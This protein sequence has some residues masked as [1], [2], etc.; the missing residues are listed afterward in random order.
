MENISDN[1]SL[2]DPKFSLDELKTI[3]KLKKKHKLII[4]N[5]SINNKKKNSFP[6]ESIAVNSISVKNF[7]PKSESKSKEKEKIK[8]VILY[9][10]INSYHVK[11]T[12]GSIPSKTE[13]FLLNNNAIFDRFSGSNSVFNKIGENTP[14][15]GS[16]ELSYDWN[17]KNN[18]VRI[19]ESE[20]KR[21]QNSFNSL[22][23]VGDYN[24]DNGK[25]IQKER[26]NLRYDSLYKR[27][28]TLFNQKINKD[29]EN[30]EYYDPKNINEIERKKKNYNFSSYSGRNDFRGS[31]IPTFFDKANDTPGPG[32]YYH[33]HMYNKSLQKLS[34]DSN[35][36]NNINNILL[37]KNKPKNILQLIKQKLDSDKKNKSDDPFFVMK[38]HGNIRDN[39]LYTFE[40]IY[41]MNRSNKKIVV[42]KEEELDKK[43][44]ENEKNTTSKYLYFNIKQNMELNR[45]KKML[46]NDNGRPDLFYLSP[47]RWNNKKKEFKTPGPAYY[48]Y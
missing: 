30:Y 22:P 1:N 37:E 29:I 20:L 36:R 14:G 2:H 39:R 18:C 44:R 7:K 4:I 24:V 21:F 43:L 31:K 16:Y 45:I 26:D 46:G 41:K 3:P 48:F 11:E 47:E 40:D 25:I 5:N 35:I 15:V 34:Y 19:G 9:K 8:K 32:Y 27:T 38:Q 17:L 12:L 6:T 28:K 33:P 23:G 13:K 42:D 10:S